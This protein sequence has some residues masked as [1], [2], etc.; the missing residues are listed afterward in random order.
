MTTTQSTAPVTFAPEQEDLTP[1]VWVTMAEIYGSQWLNEYGD[2]PNHQWTLEIRQLTRRQ[3]TRGIEKCKH[4]GS[5]FVPR[6]PQFLSY[7]NGEMTAE[8][9]AFA[10]Q[11]K[12]TREML[13]LPKP[14]PSEEIRKAEILKIKKLLRGGQ[15]V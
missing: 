14:E 2:V 6:L 7:C 5:P 13:A 11:L 8:Q 4:S 15:N 3:V 1:L 12:Q 9:K 10:N